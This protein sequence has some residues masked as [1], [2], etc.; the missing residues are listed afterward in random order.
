MSEVFAIIGTFLI[1]IGLQLFAL[2]KLWTSI[3][4]NAKAWYDRL[5][6]RKFL[7]IKYGPLLQYKV[8]QFWDATG[9][10]IFKTETPEERERAVRPHVERDFQK[11]RREERKRNLKS[12]ER[13]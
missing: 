6:E 13:K 10:A 2:R 1:V 12:E 4:S 3:T 11:R 7:F 8:R 9:D 5:G